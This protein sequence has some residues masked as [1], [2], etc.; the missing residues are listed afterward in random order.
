MDPPAVAA[1]TDRPSVAARE[2][3]RHAG[4]VLHLQPVTQGA[5]R[6][7]APPPARLP[8]PAPSHDGHRRGRGSLRPNSGCA[9]CRST[10]DAIGQRQRAVH[11]L[12]PRSP[13]PLPQPSA[14]ERPPS[15][16]H[17][18]AMPG[19]MAP[20]RGEDADPC[21]I[22]RERRPRRGGT[23]FS[24]YLGHP[25]RGRREAPV[26]GCEPAVSRCWQ[27]YALR[28]ACR[29]IAQAVGIPRLLRAIVTPRR[30]EGH[31]SGTAA[32]NR[33][34]CRG[35]VH[36]SASPGRIACNL[37]VEPD[38]QPF[39]AGPPDGVFL[40]QVVEETRAVLGVRNQADLDEEGRGL[41]R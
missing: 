6:G 26:M 35:D 13:P 1:C 25:S 11:P 9:R 37:V 10:M 5:S 31:R 16:Y 20:W 38:A 28:G 21:R 4:T 34:R 22:S 27:R 39:D 32:A 36:G 33:D 8:D 14:L 41:R 3:G 18:A 23:R 12:A 15:G 40:K 19:G 2:R 30:P 29:R 17:P 7:A 24:R